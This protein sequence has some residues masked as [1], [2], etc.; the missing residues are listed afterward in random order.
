MNIDKLLA[1]QAV[2]QDSN[3][4]DAILKVCGEQFKEQL[5]KI[6]FIDTVLENLLERRITDDIMILL[7]S[8]ITTKGDKVFVSIINRPLGQD[9]I[10]AVVLDYTLIYSGLTKLDK[11]TTAQLIT[12]IQSHIHNTLRDYIV[13]NVDSDYI[14]VSDGKV[15]LIVDFTEKFKSQ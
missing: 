1:I 2:K 10:F 7:F 12:Q 8:N 9:P 13:N 5:D 11:E 14:Q 6:N 3:N 4:T 15:T